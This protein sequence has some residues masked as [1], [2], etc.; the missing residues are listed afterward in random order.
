MEDHINKLSP[1][2]LLLAGKAIFIGTLIMFKSSYLNNVFPLDA[3]ATIQFHKKYSNT[4]GKT[5]N[6]NL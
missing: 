6:L 3:K 4:Y 2:T 5:R 1:R